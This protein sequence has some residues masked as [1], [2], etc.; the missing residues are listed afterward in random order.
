MAFTIEVHE[1]SSGLRKFSERNVGVVDTNNTSSGSGAL[2]AQ[3]TG[4]DNTAY[5]VN[6]LAALTVG[7]RNVAVGDNAAAALTT[8][9]DNVA[10]GATAL[11]ANTTGVENIAI[12]TDAL[13]ACTIGTQNIAIGDDACLALTTA[14]GCVAIGRD[15]LVAVTTGVNNTAVGDTAGNTIT[16]GTGNV[17]I[18]QAVITSAATAVDQILIGR[19]FTGIANTSFTCGVGANTGTLGIDGSD[20]TWA[21]ASDV[22]LKKN[23]EDFRIGLDFINELRPVSYEWRM[24]G[25]VEDKTLLPALETPLEPGDP[26][27]GFH[28]FRYYGLVAQEVKRTM[29]KYPFPNGQHIWYE[30][31]NGVQEIAPGDV[32]LMLVNAVKTLSTENLELARRIGKLEK[33]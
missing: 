9:T 6:A 27:R 25:E 12:G 29:D 20:T 8:G 5:G 31:N 18:G 21:A 23:I 11:D 22:R 16:T 13:G 19:G 15:A 33:A 24:A 3:T 17:C 10:V 28:G 2:A 1:D 4:V 32:V 14:T 7:E 30:R 26:V